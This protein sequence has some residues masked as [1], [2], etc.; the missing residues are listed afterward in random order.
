MINSALERQAK[1]TD[2]LVHRLIEELDGKNLADPNAN[3]SSSSYAV[4]FTQTNPQTSGTSAG[5]STL[6]NLSAQ[7]MNHFHSRITIDGSTPTLEMP[8][9]TMTSMFGQGY[10]QTTPSFSIPKL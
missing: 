6:P 4:N 2:E 7:P 1:S 9:Q 10:T 5:G 3:P 8:Q